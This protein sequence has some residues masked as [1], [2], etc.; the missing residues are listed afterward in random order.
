MTLVNM[1]A[2]TAAGFGVSADETGINVRE[3]RCTVEPEYIEHL[4]NKVNE[5]RGSAIGAM[6]LTLSIS[7][8]IL[9][10]TGI[11]AATATAAVTVANSKTYFGAPTTGL[12]LT[13]GEVTESRD[14]WKD[15][16]VDFEA[17][18]GRTVS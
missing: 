9:L 4:P 11:M 3:F 5:V 17:F 15:V 14:G 8:E 7:G 2:S 16:S 12:T 10:T 13:R 18:A 6:K 1:S